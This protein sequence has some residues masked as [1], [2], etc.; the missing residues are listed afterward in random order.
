MCILGANLDSQLGDW[1]TTDIQVKIRNHMD[2]ALV[3]QNGIIRTISNM[4]CSVYLP[5]E[6]RSVSVD[7]DQLEPIQPGPGDKFKVIMGEDRE[8]TGVVHSIDGNKAICVIGN[9]TTYK[10]LNEL[11]KIQTDY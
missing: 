4:L 6:D 7:S 10:S 5:A 2:S 9:E 1:C 8:S 11:C 3:N